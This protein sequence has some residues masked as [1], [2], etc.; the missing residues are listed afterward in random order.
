MM[1][2][3]NIIIADDHQLFRNGVKALL[4]N[5]KDNLQVVAE[6]GNINQLKEKLAQHQADLLLLDISLPDGNGLH[7]L[8][9]FKELYSDLKII[10]L[11]MH[12]EAQYVVQSIKKGA[13]GYLLKDSDENELLEAIDTVISGKRYFKERVSELILQDLSTEAN[14]GKDILSQRE[15]EIVQLV[16]KGLTTKEI[17]D[18]LFVSI[19]TVETHRAKIMKKLQVSNS[20]E[21]I[22]MALKHKLIDPL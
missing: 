8:E 13:D 1:T 22:S 16:A 19:R 21:M 15:K 4:A 9:E 6:A 17:A 12:D 14:K 11:T 3:K 10:M 18:Q 20:A 5:R 7:M 2:K